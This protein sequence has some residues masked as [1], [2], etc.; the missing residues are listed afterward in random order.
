MRKVHLVGIAGAGM[1]AIAQVLHERGEA[2]SGSDLA[3]SVY[4]QGL[5]R[6]GVKIAYGHRAQNVAE[7]DVVVISSAVPAS[8]PEVVEARRRGIP[9]LRRE[10]FLGEL[11]SGWRTIAV[12]GT[13]G[14]TTTTGLIAW[15]LDRAGRA[16]SFIVGGMLSDFGT[17]ARSGSGAE[18]VI[19]A[20]EYDRAFLGLHPSIAVVTSIE[21]DHPDMFATPADYLEAFRAFIDQAQETIIVCLDD[22]TAASLARP[23]LERITYGVEAGADWRAEEIRPNQAGGSDFL[24]L[25]R[26]EVAGLARTRLPGIHNVRNSLGAMA[27]ADR[28]G[29]A[30]STIQGAIADFHGTQRRFELLGESHGVTVI[31]DY[32]HHPTEIKATLSAARWRYPQADLWAVF[33]PHT[34]SRARAFIDAFGGAFGEAN[35]VVVTEIFASREAPDPSMTGEMVARHI[36]HP[37]VRFIPDLTEAARLLETAVRPGSVVVTLSAG[38]GNQVGK[39]LLEALEHRREDKANG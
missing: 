26:G 4:S 30:F 18:F 14:K 15:L 12:A 27:A 39:Q 36:E 9:V 22:P 8:N 25:R 32:A 1:S 28:C 5:E 6:A 11:T 10:A 17:N 7:A 33:Q 24:V 2:V 3:G 13:H 35:H 19:E 29:V 38:D 16:P 20:D 21:H 23:S 31:D 37:D 34:F